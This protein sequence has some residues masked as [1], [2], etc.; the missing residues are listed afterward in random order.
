MFRSKIRKFQSIFLRAKE[1]KSIPSAKNVDNV[2]E[3]LNK[4]GICYVPLNNL[5]SKNKFFENVKKV[6]DFLNNF[7]INLYEK[8]SVTKFSTIEEMKEYSKLNKKSFC[9]DRNTDYYFSSK[10]EAFLPIDVN[11]YDF[12]EPQYLNISLEEL[13]NFFKS[14]YIEKILR[15]ISK[16]Y[17]KDF[18]LSHASLYCYRGNN[19]PRWIHYDSFKSHIKIFIALNDM[20]T[21]NFGPYCY[22]IGS[23]KNKLLKFL[24]TFVNLVFKSDVG[25]NKTD[26]SLLSKIFVTPAFLNMS[27]ILIS[28]NSGFHGDLPSLNNKLKKD[29]IV[30]NLHLKE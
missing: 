6:S 15:S 4:F 22:V 29:I 18:C 30:L 24:N 26:G 1:N 8:N 21:I 19:M 3:I 23:H 11:M 25:S 2:G 27:D 17:K 14:N 5:E 12:I 7:D 28:D 13:L 10:H 9:I 16:S 20:N